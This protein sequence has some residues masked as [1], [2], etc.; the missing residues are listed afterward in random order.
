MDLAAIETALPAQIV[1]AVATMPN[2]LNNAATQVYVAHERRSGATVTS[3]ECW[4]RPAGDLE[5]ERVRLAKSQFA[6]RYEG[7]IFKQDM[8]QAERRDWLAQLRAYFHG[9]RRPSTAARLL[10]VTVEE[11]ELNPHP[12]EGP[13]GALGF[14]LVFHGEGQEAA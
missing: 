1:A 13:D 14:A 11:G 6:A 5:L 3:P 2:G 12:T 7:L 10:Y 4:L 9:R 8:T